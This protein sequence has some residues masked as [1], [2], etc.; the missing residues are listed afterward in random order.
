M[1]S[2][3]C[4]LNLRGDNSH[5]LGRIPRSPFRKRVSSLTR[6]VLVVV[7]RQSIIRARGTLTR[8][9]DRSNQYRQTRV[10]Y[11]EHRGDEQR[12]PGT[13]RRVHA[14]PVSGELRETHLRLEQVGT[15]PKSSGRLP[16]HPRR[17]LLD[18]QMFGARIPGRLRKAP[19]I[20][21]NSQTI[22]RNASGC[23][24]VRLLSCSRPDIITRVRS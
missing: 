17:R 18:Q 16:A 11:D 8:I 4:W 21:C 6:W 14:R 15:T 24:I 12:P 7:K 23:G 13:T 5:S 19:H 10:S 2:G 9:S 3:D 20:V 22:D 1:L